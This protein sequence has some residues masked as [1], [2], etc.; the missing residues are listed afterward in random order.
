MG[1]PA[2]GAAVSPA[3]IRSRQVVKLERL[4]GHGADSGVTYRFFVQPGSRSRL[5]FW[6]DPKDVP[7]FEGPTALFE[8]ASVDKVWRVLRRVEDR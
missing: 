6:F 3:I 2:Q 5:F 8:I 7:E 4:T 1:S